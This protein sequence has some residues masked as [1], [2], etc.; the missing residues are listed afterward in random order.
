MAGRRRSR[1]A[2]AIALVRTAPEPLDV[3]ETG[4]EHERE[5]EA[6]QILEGFRHLHAVAAHQLS[7]GHQPPRLGV[8][9]RERRVGSR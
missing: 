9:D 3:L 7:A 8:L 2:V 4:R 5:A 1:T 6:R